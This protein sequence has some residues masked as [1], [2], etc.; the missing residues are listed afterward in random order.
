MSYRIPPHTNHMSEFQP[1][2][3]C[4]EFEA[5]P[6]VVVKQTNTLLGLFNQGA[7]RK[8]E[9]AKD[10]FHDYTFNY[11]KAAE[12][13]SG[14]LYDAEGILLQDVDLEVREAAHHTFVVF[15]W[16]HQIANHLFYPRDFQEEECSPRL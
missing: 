7:I 15:A 13:G 14:A 9:L 3:G 5:S 2:V 16:M 1:V 12:E 10:Y 6:F 8:P 11:L 4:R